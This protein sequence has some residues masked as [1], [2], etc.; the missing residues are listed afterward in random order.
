[1]INVDISLS[2]VQERELRNK[3][4]D[5]LL[6]I[7]HDNLH[8]LDR[9]KGTGWVEL[10]ILTSEAELEQIK[11]IGER[12]KTQAEL[13]IVIGI[14]GSYAGI[15][16]GLEMLNKKDSCP[17]VKFMG[18]TF[19]ATE[20]T[21]CLEEA[22]NKEVAVC[23][24]SKSGTTTETLVAFNLIENLI[25]KKYRK[26]AEYK[27]RIYV[28]TDY[29]KG[30]LREL[31]TKENYTALI[32][33]RTVGGRYSVLTPVGL[34]PF[35][36]AG[37]DI[38][39]ILEGAQN[40]YKECFNLNLDNPAYR[41]ALVRYILHTKKK[42][43]IE[44]M[45]SFDDRLSAFYEWYK[46]LFAE[47][48]GKDGKGLFVSSLTYSTDLH[49]FG[50]FIQ[51]GSPILFETFLEISKPNKDLKLE[52]F[53]KDNPLMVLEGKS[54]SELIKATTIGV[55]KAHQKAGVPIIKI[56]TD[57]L[58][59]FSFGELVQFFE[60]SCAV[61]GY[62]LGVNPFNQPGVEEYKNNTREKLNNKTEN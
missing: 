37:L 44:V 11:E 55:V 30:Y 24:I 22:K 56:T 48:E 9:S 61:S 14:G 42:K 49:S 1:M 12:I 32:I 4:Y 52:G 26:G 25:K 43:A 31:A 58:N 45:A 10:P 54:L 59:E 38:Q 15:K 57:C 33:P 7:A 28:I 41:Y 60:T 50:Q 20:L 18:T 21:E 6:R 62:L 8:A 39:K 5:K 23:V 13:L 40:A 3:K 51:D 19:S 53:A 35:Y 47:S 36:V 17:R 27:N 29:E 2:G 16:A 46:Q 34:L